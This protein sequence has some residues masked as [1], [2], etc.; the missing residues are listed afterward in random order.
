MLHSLKKIVAFLFKLDYYLI[1]KTASRQ[2]GCNMDKNEKK[3]TVRIEED[4]YKEFKKAL[5]EN[6][7]TMK[8][9]MTDLI[10]QYLKEN[11]K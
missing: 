5:I 10:K 2:G 11:S 6:N 4:L 8:A 9:C 1:N 3:I 7:I